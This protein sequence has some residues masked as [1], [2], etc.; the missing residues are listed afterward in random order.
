MGGDCF[1][2]WLCFNLL[3]SLISFMIFLDRPPLWISLPMAVR[4]HGSMPTCK[5]R[6][7]WYSGA[8]SASSPTRSW[9]T[10]LLLFWTCITG[11]RNYFQESYMVLFELRISFSI[12]FDDFLSG[13]DFISLPSSGVKEGHRHFQLEWKGNCDVFI[14]EKGERRVLGCK[15]MK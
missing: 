15:W 1:Q 7:A 5:V 13:N 9:F 12:E 11:S 10:T 8:A 14:P 2:C 3:L 4:S 6:Y